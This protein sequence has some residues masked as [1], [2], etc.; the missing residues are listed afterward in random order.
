MGVGGECTK[1]KKI[2]IINL[3]KNDATSRW[4][5][6]CSYT[7]LGENEVLDGG[8]VF[9]GVKLKLGSLFRFKHTRFDICF[10]STLLRLKLFLQ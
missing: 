4:L 8:V 6:T 10:W 2:Y 3:N 1:V 5:A 9:G 7:Q